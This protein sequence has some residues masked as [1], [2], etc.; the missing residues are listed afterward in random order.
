MNRR[1]LEGISHSSW[2]RESAG[3]DEAWFYIARMHPCRLCLIDCLNFSGMEQI[4]EN[5]EDV[6][7][8][9]V[10]KYEFQ[11]MTSNM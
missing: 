7:V 3:P 9:A 5:K 6:T 8:T 2:T 4:P 1:L 10:N 11:E